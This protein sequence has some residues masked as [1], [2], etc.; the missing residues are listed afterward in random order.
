MQI[1]SY[2][3]GFLYRSYRSGKY[4]WFTL[5]SL[6]CYMI[7]QSSH[8]LIITLTEISVASQNEEEQ[9]QD[10]TLTEFM[11]TQKQLMDNTQLIFQKHATATSTTQFSG[12]YRS[13]NDEK[14][15][16]DTSQQESFDRDIHEKIHGENPQEKKTCEPG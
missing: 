11:K 10:I 14:D 13:G 7:I 12:T 16:N 9:E 6:L 5:I 4:C 2:N 3:L 15:S 8:H 1:F